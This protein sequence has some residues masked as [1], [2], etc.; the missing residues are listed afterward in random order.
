MMNR[1]LL[2]IAAC[3]ARAALGDPVWVSLGATPKGEGPLVVTRAAADGL[4]F[5]VALDR[6]Q[7]EHRVAVGITY[8]RLSVPSAGHTADV[9]LPELPYIGRLV[10]VPQGAAM[11]AVFTPLDSVE[12]SPYVVWPAQEPAP[13]DAEGST[14]VKNEAFYRGGEVFP[15]APVAVAD[16]GVI[17]GC[18]VARV[19]VFPFSYDPGRSCL[20]VYTRGRIVVRFTGGSGIFVEDRMRSRFFE[21][22]LSRILL[23]YGAL[24]GFD[25]LPKV[26]GGEGELLIVAADNLADNVA[27]FAQWRTAQGM[28][29]VVVTRSEAGYTESGMCQYIQDVYD[30]WDS[31]PSFVLLVG[32]AENLPTNH[33]YQHPTQLNLTAA[34]LWFFTVDGPDFFADIH[35]GRISADTPSQLNQ[36]LAKVLAYE[37]TPQPGAW[38]NHAFLAS[39]LEPGMYFTI[40]SDAIYSYL[41]SQGYTVDRAYENGFPPG[42]TQDVI[43]NFNAGSFL[44]NHRDHGGRENWVHPSFWVSDFGQVN[45]GSML[46]VVFSI[47]CLSGYFDAET[48][49]TPGTFESFS[50]QLLRKYPGGAVAVV[51]SSRT[52]YSGYNDELDRGLIDAMWPGF[53]PGY[54]GAMS[55]NPWQSPSYRPGAV[56]NYGKWYMYDKYV[57]TGG[58]GYPWEPTPEQ[59]RLQMEMYHCHGDPTLDIHTAA[60][61]VMAVGHDPII[62]AGAQSVDVSVDTEG[63]LAAVTHD[64]ALVG[65]A[66]VAG[67]IAHVMFDEPVPPGA[68]DLVVTA[69]NRIPH[70]SSISVMVTDG[71]LVTVDGVLAEDVAGHV[72]GVVEQGDSVTLTITLRNH[73][74]V[75]APAVRGRL[76]SA[77]P[78]VTVGAATVQYGTIPAGQTV[79]AGPY[80]LR[81]TGGV[82]DG[83]VVPLEL[84]V[85]SGDST[86]LR[87]LSLL[88]HAGVPSVAQVVIDDSWG[89]G[90]GRAEPGETIAL[91]ARLT[92]TGSGTASGVSATLTCSSPFVTIL[93]GGTS[94]ADIGP[95]ET[96]SPLS[97][98]QVSISPECPSGPV[99][100]VLTVACFGPVARELDFAISVGIV[101]V[102]V[103][104]ADE[105][106]TETRL[107]DAMAQTGYPFHVYLAYAS[108]VVPLDT[109]ARYPVVVW[110]GGDNNYSSASPSNQEMLAQY[111]AGGGALFFTAENYLTSHGASSFTANFLHVAGYTTNV[112]AINTSGI[113][114]DPITDGFGVSLNFPT[115]LSNTP[116][117]ILPDAEAAPI[118]RAQ[119]GERV[120]ALRYPSAGAG[121]YRVVFMAVPFEALS[122]GGPAPNN[123]ESLLER[124]LLWLQGGVDA[125]PP[126]AVGDLSLAPA[127]GSAVTLTWSPASDNVAVHHYAIHRHV[128]AYFLPQSETLLGTTPETTWVDEAGGGDCD[129]D[130]FYLVIAVDEAGNQ[131]TPSNRVGERET[132]L[133]P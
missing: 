79:T 119:P 89:N 17:R 114:D 2:V 103:V 34:D 92:N 120:V 54:P 28:P 127:G 23:N 44:V 85:E 100:F 107:V 55:D 30:T 129:V 59:T 4:E 32:D 118:L 132:L 123:P 48:D 29:T 63:A 26:R 25:P 38:N 67:G 42:T 41:L 19:G 131:S 112:Q 45:N 70:Q 82:E 47:N 24:G 69:H 53:D 95:N 64:G 133:Q 125:L 93:T 81:V 88:V 33:R 65:R 60:P 10:A 1:W 7:V 20:R 56:L 75:D 11:E 109:L 108:G 111:L 21:P 78:G 126:G 71:W 87:P 36:I 3:A 99:S 115:E 105:E 13:D 12:L 15:P 102:L 66:F 86:W 37:K 6:M 46:P 31:P 5:E 77:D 57:L 101:S 18:R 8:Q 27:S 72:D 16:A 73:G 43:A 68:L 121:T 35:Y 104:D 124:A 113:A 91:E 130:H 49:G 76:Q 106:T 9:G 51:S 50:E 96:A 98:F 122:P 80:P 117:E 52:S 97:A 39:Y 84:L 62:P 90:N 22:L 14:F 83:H 58:A 40:T 116:D 61:V 128:T 74:A 110:T 94:Y